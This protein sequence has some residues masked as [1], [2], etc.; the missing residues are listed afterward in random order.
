MIRSMIRS[1]ISDDMYDSDERSVCSRV[2]VRQFV[3]RQ[4]G[5]GQIRT[6]PV[7]RADLH[8]ERLPRRS[9]S[10]DLS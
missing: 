2:V 4:A 8:T 6:S 10:N 3:V 9:K 1:M 7:T 5:S